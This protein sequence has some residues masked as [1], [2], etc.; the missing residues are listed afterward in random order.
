MCTITIAKK[1][2]RNDRRAAVLLLATLFLVVMFAL[3]AFA[4][5]IGYISLAQTQLQS[6]ADAAALAAASYIPNDINTAR[7]KA[8][9]FATQN[10]AGGKTIST[11]SVTVEFGNWDVTARLHRRSARKR[12]QSHHPARRRPRRP[13]SP[14]FRA[15][16]GMSGTSRTASAVAMTN[17][18]DICF[19]VDLSGSMND[20][21][22]PCWVTYEITNAYS[23]TIANNLVQN[24]YNDFGFGTFPGTLQ[25]VGQP[26]G[27]TQNNNAYATLSSSSGPLT[28]SSIPSTY[29]ITSSDNTAAKRKVKAYKWIID[30]QLAQIMPNAL[31]TPISSNTASR[32]YWTAYLDYVIYSQPTGASISPI[33]SFGNPQPTSYPDATSTEIQSYRNKLGYRTYVQFMMDHGREA[34]P[35]GAGQYTPL[36]TSSAYC[37]YHSETT[38]GGT[39][40]FP[41]REMP[42]HAGRRSIIAALEIVKQRNLTVSDSN[43]RDWISIITFDQVTNPSAVTILHPLNYNYDQA[44][45]DSTTMQAVSDISASTATE[46]GLIAAKNLL[47]ANGR[48]YTEKVVVLLTDGS[49]NLYYSSS[50][51]ISTYI[52][53][54]PSSN[55]YS[56]SSYNSQN[57]AL[58]QAMSMQSSKWRLFPVGI[59]SGT[60]YDFMDRFAR[61]GGSANPQGQSPRGTGD[62]SQYEQTLKTIF[63]NIIN[64][65]KA[66]LVQ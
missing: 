17:P 60:N 64:N 39:F 47:T 62:P 22:E 10:K 66:R 4:V 20:D 61:L 49:P 51:T 31:P 40:N 26:L 5:D 46:T 37:P 34:V 11:N 33:T 25:H 8:I 2:K 65:P 36:S 30:Y 50:S 7:Q 58:M 18:R 12:G 57:A 3:L 63:Q 59:A 32:T 13:D 44:M 41:P 19:V 9:T 48:T 28:S 38:D 23:S 14:V 27:I 21:S 42:T 53:Q 29:R 15:I 56:G 1:G 16:L 35:T 45:Q 54:H 6:A 55:F 43:Q 52:S 24:V